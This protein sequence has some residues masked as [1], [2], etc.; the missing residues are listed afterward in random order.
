MS[1][2]AKIP[3]S[4][5]TP[6]TVISHQHQPKESPASIEIGGPKGPEPTRFGDWEQNGRCSDF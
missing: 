5:L 3:S 6:E 4:E 2:N 1:D